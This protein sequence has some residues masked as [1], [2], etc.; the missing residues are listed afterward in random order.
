MKRDFFSKDITKKKEKNREE[1]ENEKIRGTTKVVG[2]R[3]VNK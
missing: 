3:M 1:K 2:G